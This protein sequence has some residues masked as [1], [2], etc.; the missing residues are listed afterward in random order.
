MSVPKVVPGISDPSILK[1]VNTWDNAGAY[2]ERAKKLACD[3]VDSFQKNYADKGIDPAVAAECP[4][5][6][7]EVKA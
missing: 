1:P 2:E 5:A 7:A 4:A 3:F 6:S